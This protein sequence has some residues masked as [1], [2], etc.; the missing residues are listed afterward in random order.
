MQSN[1]MPVSLALMIP[2]EIYIMHIMKRLGK[3]TFHTLIDAVGEEDS[4]EK[5]DIFSKLKVFDRILI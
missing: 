1:Q 4:L 5:K 3:D 2:T